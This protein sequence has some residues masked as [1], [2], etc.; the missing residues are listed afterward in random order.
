M[1]AD[2]EAA[3]CEALAQEFSIDQVVPV[4][5]NELWWSSAV[6]FVTWWPV[7][8]LLFVVGVVALLAALAQP[9]TGA[10]EGLFV[11]CFA[12]VFFGSYLIG[13]ADWVELILVVAGL[14]LLAFELF[15]T[16]GFGVMGGL[17][18]LSLAAALLLSFQRFVI[19]ETDFQWDLLGQ[20]LAKTAAGCSLSLVGMALAL[21]FLPK[22]GLFKGL[23]HDH[24]QAAVPVTTPGQER[25][26]VG[27]LCVAE[28]ALR[29]VGK[30]KVGGDALEAVAE[31]G[32]LDAGT[33]VVVVGYRGNELV[34]TA[35]PEAIADA[36][37][38]AKAEPATM[39][40][41]SPSDPTPKTGKES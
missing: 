39:T 17:G 19:P 35:R 18:A 1:E 8:V 7:K 25:A 24:T 30:V 41:Q 32:M 4:Q 13:L 5:V 28:T 27:T 40:E 14:A 20:N 12:A 9:G 33:T 37:A 23:M 34:V 31:N 15:V 6:R 36:E 21:R 11:V 10:P 38:A 22:A 2:D 3:L 26:P 29:P 16:P